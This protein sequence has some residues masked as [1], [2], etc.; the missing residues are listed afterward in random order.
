MLSAPVVDTFTEDTQKLKGR[1][2]SVSCGLPGPSMHKVLFE[3]S[4]DIWWVWDLILNVILPLL[5][6]CW[7]FSFAFGHR[8]SFMVGSNIFLSMVIEQLDA[9]LECSQEKMSIC[10][11]TLPSCGNLMNSMKRRNDMTLKDELSRLIGA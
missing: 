3:P 4:K 11:S 8:I 5:P 7:G 2:G 9:I 1:S 6:S 10:L